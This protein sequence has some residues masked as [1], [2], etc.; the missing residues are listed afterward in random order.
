MCDFKDLTRK[1]GCCRL[2]QVWA[3]RPATAFENVSN[4]I[5]K[6]SRAF[7]KTRHSNIQMVPVEKANYL[8]AGFLAKA[9]AR[10]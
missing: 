9:F 6:K 10:F 8:H 7:E 5:A 3:V 4:F 1:R 2:G